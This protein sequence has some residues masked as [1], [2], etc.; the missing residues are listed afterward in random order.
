MTDTE[1]DYAK[2]LE[3]DPTPLMVHIEEWIRDK[4]D[5]DPAKEAKSKAEAFALGVYL[6]THLRTYHQESPENQE[7]L[8]EARTAADARK[9]EAQQKREERS[10]AGVAPRGRIPKSAA[11]DKVPAKRGRK[12][13][14]AQVVTETVEPPKRARRARAKAAETPVAEPAAEK[15]AT[16]PKRRARR[17]AAVP[18]EK[19]AATQ[20]APAK[21]DATVT[22]IRRRRAAPKQGEAAF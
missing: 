3:K 1:I 13:K 19:A 8:A 22:P 11:E 18:G 9:S 7:R 15:V 6:T 5:F 2:Y 17:T 12:P 4:T 21:A 14:A 20:A 10:A 16:A